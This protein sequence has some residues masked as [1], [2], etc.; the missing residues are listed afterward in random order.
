MVRRGGSRLTAELQRFAEV[1]TPKYEWPVTVRDGAVAFE[2]GNGGYVY[3]V[4][5]ATVFA[6]SR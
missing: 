3:A 2:D 6:L 1:Y 5:A 4:Q